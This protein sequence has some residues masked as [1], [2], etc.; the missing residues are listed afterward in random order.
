MF[1][2]VIRFGGYSGT[3]NRPKRADTVFKSVCKSLGYRVDKR[4]LPRSQ[5]RGY[6]WF[7]DPTSWDFIST[8]TEKR[9]LMRKS[10]QSKQTDVLKIDNYV[11]PDPE[12]IYNNKYQIE[13][14]SVAIKNNWTQL[15]TTAIDGLPIDID[16]AVDAL[17]DDERDWFINEDLPVPALTTT[18][19]G[20]YISEF[21][22][23]ITPADLDILKNRMRIPWTQLRSVI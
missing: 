15:V 7:I 12:S 18:L 3:S 4:R 23:N 16:W 17:R 9:R 10:V 22:C 19:I 20:I 13:D 1:N 5:G 6:V 21:L 11:I 8:I 14:R 2:N